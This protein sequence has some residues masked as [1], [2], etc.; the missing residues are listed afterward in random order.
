MS[1]CSHLLRLSTLTAVALL[2]IHSELRAQRVPDDCFRFDRKYFSWVGRPPGGGAVFADSSAVVRFSWTPHPSIVASR[3]L[4]VPSMLV[5]SAAANSWLRA[6]RWRVFAKDSVEVSW[7][8]NLYGTAFRLG[9]RGN[10]LLGQVRFLTDNGPEPPAQ[11]AS[12]IRIP[13]P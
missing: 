11:R 12:A 6:S 9:G 3:L 2:G 8:N 7:Y 5:D 13:C 4:T 10:T 1:A